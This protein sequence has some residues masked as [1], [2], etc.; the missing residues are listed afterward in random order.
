MSRLGL[1]FLLCLS[2]FVL[3]L[4][5]LTHAGGEIKVD[6]SRTRIL[7]QKEP[8]EVQLAVDNSTGETLN[9]DVQLELLN[10]QDRVDAR[11]TSTQRM[12]PGS[13]TLKLTL[14]F[15]L[16]TLT[17]PERRESVWYRLRYRLSHEGKITEGILSLSESPDLFE[18]RVVT[19]AIAREGGMYQ[20]RVNATHPITHKPAAKVAV[21]GELLLEDDNRSI[22]LHAAKTTDSDGYALL[23]FQLPPH[24]PQFPHTTHP[25]GGEVKLVGRRGAMVAETT[26]DVLVDQFARTLITPDKPI[27]QPGQTMHVRAL[28]FTPSRRAL[29]NQNVLIRICDPET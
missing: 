9:A 13:Q 15:S 5:P 26:G 25:A 22:K 2:V 4:V 10:P 6:E 27:Y 8:V 24:F 21:T 7:I 19:S 12:T 18:L 17:D 28:M 16:T 1:L 14:P 23:G 29:A 3:A 11:S 20:V